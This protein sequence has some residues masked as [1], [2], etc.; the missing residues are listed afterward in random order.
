MLS[1]KQQFRLY[2]IL[3]EE[4]G[5]V[6]ADAFL[7]AVTAAKNSVNIAALTRAIDAGDVAGVV[8]AINFGAPTL[9][10]LGE[11]VRGTFAAG[12]GLAAEIIP[13][14]A[15][16]GF[17]M[18]NPRAEAWA[19]E[20]A[21]SLIQG[22]ER[23]T[24]AMV[25][26]VLQDRIQAGRSSAKAALDIVGR[27]DGGRRQGGFI[28]LTSEQTDWVIKARQQLT[29]LD[30]SYFTRTLR[31]RRFDAQVRKAIDSGTPLSQA[32]IDKITGRYQD[33]VLKFR[34]DTIARNESHTALA[35]GQRE[36]FSQLIESGKVETVTKRWQWNGGG[37]EPRV[38]HQAMDTAPARPFDEPFI[39]PDGAALQYPHDPAGGVEHSIHCRCTVV[40]RPILPV[41]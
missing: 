40:Y 23:D 28:G 38:D 11:A 24:E 8:E 4:Q 19:R 14:K 34:G 1:A 25:R 39:F 15:I 6:I 13:S 5:K 17:D 32:H 12:G 26:V 36:G 41:E 16:F 30:G 3:L 18:G 37:Q 2:T 31:D 21:G 27:I 9:S 22:I 35:A 10:P 33:R 20:K 29:D 7:R